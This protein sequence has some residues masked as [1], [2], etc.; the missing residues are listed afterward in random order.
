MG[1]EQGLAFFP[2]NYQSDFRFS[3]EKTNK[4]EGNFEYLHKATGCLE[5]KWVKCEY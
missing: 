2:V 5:V 4:K 3:G 1:E